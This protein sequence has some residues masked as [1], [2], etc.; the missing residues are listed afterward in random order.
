MGKLTKL[1]HSP[2][3]SK[4]SETE[5]HTAISQSRWQEGFPLAPAP[6]PYPYPGMLSYPPTLP[7]PGYAP[8]QGY[9][10]SQGLAAAPHG[11]G[12]PPAG[13]YAPPNA[14]AMGPAPSE[15]PYM[16]PPA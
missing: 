8:Q 2:A 6:G 15:Y 7:S 5:S 12:M 11:Y 9:D 13:A 14:G 3:V 10:F 4:P 16:A 1:R